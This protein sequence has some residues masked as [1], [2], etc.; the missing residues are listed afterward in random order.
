VELEGLRMD[1]DVSGSASVRLSTVM[2][3]LTTIVRAAIARDLGQDVEVLG[4]RV[5]DADGRELDPNDAVV[6]VGFRSRQA[7]ESIRSGGAR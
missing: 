1:G 2:A 6:I 4:L 5:V 7:T 3:E